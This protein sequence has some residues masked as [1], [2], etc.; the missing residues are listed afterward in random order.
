MLVEAMNYQEITKEVMRDFEKLRVN[1][2]PRLSDAY[3]K[4]RRKFKIDKSRTYPKACPVKT[5]TKNTWILFFSKGPGKDKY[6]G[7]DS[8]TV[9]YVVY[10]YTSRGLTVINLS[11]GGYLELYYGHFFKRY[12]ERMKLGLDKPIDI[13]TNYFLYGSHAVY[14]IINKNDK[15]CTLGVSPNGFLLGEFLQ[16]ERFLI[17]KT[18]VSRDL[19]Y[20]EQGE[21]EKKLIGRLEMDI[22]RANFTG[23]GAEK[24]RISSAVFNGLAGDYIDKPAAG[25]R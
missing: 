10:Y 24:A 9:T 1:T 21:A 3:E 7:I 16:E 4:E 18:F 12:N 25:I 14:Q 2:E 19:T 5:A 15:K 22:M 13:V 11:S 6:Q 23:N 8:T 20:D 17:N